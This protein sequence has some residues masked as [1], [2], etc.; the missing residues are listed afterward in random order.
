MRA[1]AIAGQ[2]R[3]PRQRRHLSVWPALHQSAS[4][5]CTYHLNHLVPHNVLDELENIRV[6]VN[7]VA[8]DKHLVKGKQINQAKI[9]IRSTTCTRPHS[10]LLTICEISCR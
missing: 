5:Y 3:A 6:R 1:I 4:P 8:K 10:C 2:E 9:S 7:D